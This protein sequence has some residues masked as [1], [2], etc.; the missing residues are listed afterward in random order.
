MTVDTLTKELVF[1][2][3]P[4]HKVIGEIYAYLHTVKMKNN[5]LVSNFK[6]MTTS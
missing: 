1:G 4:G 6:F 3:V 5:I 2:S